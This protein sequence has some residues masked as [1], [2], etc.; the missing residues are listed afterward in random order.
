MLLC[1][2]KIKNILARVFDI[3][4]IFPLCVFAFGGLSLYLDYTGLFCLHDTLEHIRA[5]LAVAFGLTPY[6]DFFEHHH[7]LLWYLFAPVAKLFYLNV[8]IVPFFRFVG[9]LGSWGVLY[10]VYKIAAQVY[11]QKVAPYAVLSLLSVPH[12]WA[13]VITFRPDVFMYLFFFIGL[14]CFL[15]YLEDKQRKFLI[16][17]YLSMVISFLFLQKIAFV[18]LGFGV[19]NLWCLVKKRVNVKDA[20]VSGCVAIVPLGLMLALLFYKG[21]LSDFVY[22]NYT[23]NNHMRSYFGGA[24]M[25]NDVWFFQLVAAFVLIFI[26]R[27]Y[28]FSQK[29]GVIFCCFIAQVIS[30]FYFAPNSYYYIPF[31]MFASFIVAKSLSKYRFSLVALFVLF[32]ISLKTLCP[33]QWVKDGYARYDQGLRYAVETKMQDDMLDFRL[34]P[35]NLFAKFKNFYWFGFHDVVIVDQIHNADKTFELMDFIQ[36]I[37]PKYLVLEGGEDYLVLKNRKWFAYRNQLLLQKASQRP[38]WRERLIPIHPDF[39]RA[40]EIWKWVNKHYTRDA[41]TGLYQRHD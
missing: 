17:S 32:L 14:K 22:Y 40:P 9:T 41:R 24:Y 36:Q 5:S 29:D 26:L 35:I 37:H 16:L 1:F 4:V 27:V 15:T 23:F 21:M 31:F 10:L 6:V 8:Y 28:R 18:L 7:P 38:S 30:L 39:W 2:E 19:F 3:R 11:G 33:P 34:H 20:F 25:Q 12:L 13:D